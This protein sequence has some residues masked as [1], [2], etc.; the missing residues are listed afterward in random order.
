MVVY[1]LEGAFYRV[2]LRLCEQKM[3]FKRKS[4][5]KFDVFGWKLAAIV[6]QYFRRGVAD[7]VFIF[8]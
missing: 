8:N 6:V 3:V 4:V 2:L 7:N 1:P 5:E